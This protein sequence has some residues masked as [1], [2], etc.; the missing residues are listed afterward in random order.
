MLRR[1]MMLSEQNTCV[2]KMTIT[3]NITTADKIHEIFKS[4]GSG[5][6][7]YVYDGEPNEN[8]NDNLVIIV[9]LYKDAPILYARRRGRWDAVINFSNSYDAVCNIGDTYK[10]F[11]CD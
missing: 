1:R 9:V 7:F 8:V 2:G 5:Y 10:I 4:A 11:T 6:T 3:Q